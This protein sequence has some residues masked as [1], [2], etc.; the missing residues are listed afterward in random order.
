MKKNGSSLDRGRNLLRRRKRNRGG[1]GR[2]GVGCTQNYLG[3][4]G[5]EV[6]CADLKEFC[7]GGQERAQC[8][9]GMEKKGTRHF[10]C[11][12]LGEICDI[13]KR[14]EGA[15]FGGNSWMNTER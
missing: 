15:L 5:K 1:G 3:A 11:C 7:L 14:R 8:A 4:S 2:G 10:F 9:R 13:R 12:I 6:K